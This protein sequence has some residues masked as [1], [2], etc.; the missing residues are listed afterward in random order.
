MK[1]ETDNDMLVIESDRIDE[2]RQIIATGMVECKRDGLD[3]LEN[4]VPRPSKI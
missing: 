1:P 3:P 2:D 4:T